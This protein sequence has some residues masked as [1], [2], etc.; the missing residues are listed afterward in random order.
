MEEI[1]FLE[2]L[3]LIE[4]NLVARNSPP[5]FAGNLFPSIGI[6]DSRELMDEVDSS[7]LPTEKAAAVQNILIA[8]FGGAVRLKG[9]NMFFLFPIYIQHLMR[10]HFLTSQM[11]L[12]ERSRFLGFCA[13]LRQITLARALASIIASVGRESPRVLGDRLIQIFGQ[14]RAETRKS[15]ILHIESKIGRALT[16]SENT[17]SGPI[18]AEI[19]GEQHK[20]FS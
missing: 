15:M 7:K 10:I 8:K 14:D 6:D 12:E 13:V 5:V 1:E 11:S 18:F 4:G 20:Q 3:D 17:R 16:A 9:L 19:W 2:L